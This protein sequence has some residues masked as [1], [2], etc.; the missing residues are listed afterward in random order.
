MENNFRNRLLH[1][2]DYIK[3]PKFGNSLTKFLNENP[4]G[5]DDSTIARFL[6]LSETEVQQMYEEAVKLLRQKIFNDK[7]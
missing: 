7:T 1:D 2:D 4:D 5:T 3:C 6:G